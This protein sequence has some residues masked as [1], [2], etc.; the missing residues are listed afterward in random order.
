MQPPWGRD[1]VG[2]IASIAVCALLAM[3]AGADASF[4]GTNGKIAFAGAADIYS[5]TDI[6]T[7]QPD[8]NGLTQLT[9]SPGY[10]SA[11]AWSP[12]GTKIAFSA[13]GGGIVVMNADGSG[14]T[15]L[16]SG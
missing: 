6:Y 11:P 12:D 3:P 15:P 4:P 5:P 14:Q 13:G 1:V 16:T 8:G 10:D 2:R 7:V 9:T